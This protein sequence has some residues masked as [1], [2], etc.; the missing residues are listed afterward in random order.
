M[1]PKINEFQLHYYFLIHEMVLRE[2]IARVVQDLGLAFIGDANKTVDAQDFS[3]TASFCS[4]QM[5]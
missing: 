1:A 3:I 2:D 4:N 5:S